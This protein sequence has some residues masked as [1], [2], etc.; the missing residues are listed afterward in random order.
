M[1]RIRD[2]APA[3][4]SMLMLDNRQI[5]DAHWTEG[6]L[7]LRHTV[8]H[9][10]IRSGM[11]ANVETT[12]SSLEKLDGDS[13]VHIICLGQTFAQAAPRVAAATVLRSNY[14]YLLPG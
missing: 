10:P 2:L 4:Q 13:D 7:A 9:A 3:W 11:K 12:I 14:F 8:C 6:P 1:Q 5:K